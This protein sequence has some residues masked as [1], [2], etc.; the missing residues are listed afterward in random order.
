MERK[1]RFYV[2]CISRPLRGIRL[3]LSPASTPGLTY[4]NILIREY[5]F[6]FFLCGYAGLGHMAVKFGKALGLKVVV[7][8]TS[9]NKMKDAID[10]LKADKFVV[11]KDEAQFKVNRY[12]NRTFY[13]E[14]GNVLYRHIKTSIH[15]KDEQ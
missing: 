9:P 2:K 5:L 10:V 13:F 1:Y 12:V 3:F 8:S 11:T 4:V 7:L 15:S 14:K 6:P